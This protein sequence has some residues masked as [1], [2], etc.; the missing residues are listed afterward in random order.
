MSSFSCTKAVFLSILVF[1]MNGGIRIF[2]NKL[3]LPKKVTIAGLLLK[4]LLGWL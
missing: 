2:D 3:L 4:N 1:L